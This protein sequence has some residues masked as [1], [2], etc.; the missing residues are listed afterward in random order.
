MPSDSF[1]YYVTYLT[2]FEMETYMEIEV[3]KSDLIYIINNT[4]SNKYLGK[5]HICTTINDNT[6]NKNNF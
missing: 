1:K 4:S 3:W 6:T 5:S 2:M